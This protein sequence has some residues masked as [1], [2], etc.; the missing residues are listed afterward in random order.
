[1]T[2]TA[3]PM[4][5]TAVLSRSTIEKVPPID[6]PPLPDSGAI[7]PAKWMVCRWFSARTTASPVNLRSNLT[8]STKVLVLLPLSSRAYRVLEAKSPKTPRSFSSRY[9]GEP[10]NIFSMSESNATS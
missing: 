1:M 3:S 4:A 10:I 2:T 6:P 5:A 9:G 8:S 7:P